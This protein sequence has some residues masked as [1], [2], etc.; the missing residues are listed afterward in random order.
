MKNNGSSGGVQFD[1]SQ[2]DCRHHEHASG[3]NTLF[4]DELG[5]H[6]RQLSRYWFAFTLVFLID[7]FIFFSRESPSHF[8]CGEPPFHFSRLDAEEFPNILYGV[9]YLPSTLVVASS[10]IPRM[11]RSHSHPIHAFPPFDFLYFIIFRSRRDILCCN[12]SPLSCSRPS[13]RRIQSVF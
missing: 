7:Q 8:T 6:W 4:S 1:P 2:W 3:E 9:H 13:R 12:S 10:N 5:N 11:R